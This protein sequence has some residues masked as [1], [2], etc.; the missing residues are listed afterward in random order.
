MEGSCHKGGNAFAEGSRVGH[1][2]HRETAWASGR[3]EPRGPGAGGGLPP[4]GD[5]ELL[6][7]PEM[8]PPLSPGS[9]QRCSGDSGA[10]QGPA[11]CQPHCPLNLNLFFPEITSNFTHFTLK[12][13]ALSSCWLVPTARG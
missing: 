9:W 7:A 6:L 1:P 8:A 5:T 4:L 12:S 13:L 3:L 10:M 11:S 2:C